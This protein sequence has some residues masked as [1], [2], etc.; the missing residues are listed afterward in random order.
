MP[1]S[2]PQAHRVLCW[3]EEDRGCQEGVIAETQRIFGNS[4]RCSRKRQLS[5]IAN[6]VRRTLIG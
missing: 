3:R 4:G 1:P 2:T 6:T 5:F